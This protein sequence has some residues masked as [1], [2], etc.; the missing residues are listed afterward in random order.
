M[1]TVRARGL[2]EA[3]GQ[4]PVVVNRQRWTGPA[5]LVCWTAPSGHHGGTGRQGNVLGRGASGRHGGPGDTARPATSPGT[6]LIP[7]E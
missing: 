2:S 1:C 5:D 4:R 6:S 7:N 3:T